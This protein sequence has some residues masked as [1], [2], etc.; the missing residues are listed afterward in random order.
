MTEKLDHRNSF[1]RICVDSA[2]QG[3]AS[4]RVFSR[5]L[6]EPIVF[7]DLGGLLLQLEKLME[8]QDFPQAFQRI[9]TF[10]EIEP[11]AKGRFLPEGSMSTGAVASAWGKKTTF[12]LYIL[13]R[14][15]ASWQGKVDWLDESDPVPF[16]SDL[17]FLKLVTEH[18]N[19]MDLKE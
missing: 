2:E 1:F 10:T 15:S 14:R 8:E 7:S 17:E 3:R 4:G 9:R 19:K 11:S 16:D 12:V 5:R 18:L 6:R 13:S